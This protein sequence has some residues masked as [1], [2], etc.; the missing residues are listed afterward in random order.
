MFARYLAWGMLSLMFPSNGLLAS[1]ESREAV[2]RLR[3]QQGITV[4]DDG[5]WQY[6]DANVRILLKDKRYRLA[7][8]ECD[9]QLA[10]SA[11]AR[12]PT[13]TG[14]L[15]ALQ[16]AIT[17]LLGGGDLSTARSW[18][19]AAETKYGGI[20]D[21][22]PSTLSVAG[23]PKV[24][25]GTYFR[26]KVQCAAMPRVSAGLGAPLEGAKLL[27]A[28]RVSWA[29]ARQAGAI[30]AND[31]AVAAYLEQVLLPMSAA[32][33]YEQGRDY[34]SAALRYRQAS[35]GF[36]SRK[37]AKEIGPFLMPG[38]IRQIRLLD[39]KASQ[40]AA[41]AKLRAKSRTE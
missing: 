7:L 27:D 9:E 25:I 2:T 17:A 38:D 1:S 26:M 8:E 18:L 13:S 37:W 41:K 35:R 19:K 10:R 24:C 4:P 28:A 23:S 12:P 5:S 14:M 3:Q 40:C 30:I 22:L 15:S 20:Q 16:N 21:I 31:R 11:S 6:A 33:L 34:A 32:D 29:K 36:R 39:A